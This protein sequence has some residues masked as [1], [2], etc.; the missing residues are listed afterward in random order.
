MLSMNNQNP[1]KRKA[2]HTA[3]SLVSVRGSVKVTKEAFHPLP[4]HRSGTKRQMTKT[5]KVSS[6]IQN[7][8]K[9]KTDSKK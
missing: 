2:V 9:R 8:K 4:R 6:V 3:T 1:S 5:K 7:S